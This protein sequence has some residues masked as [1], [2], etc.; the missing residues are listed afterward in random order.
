MPKAKE[1]KK[2]LLDANI[3]GEMV[4]DVNIEQLKEE[5][6]K[7]KDTMLIYGV[8]EIIRKELR[9]TPKDSKVG[10]KKLRSNLLGLYDIFTRSHELSLAEEHKK[11]ADDYYKAY[12]ELGGSKPKDSILNDLIIGFNGIFSEHCFFIFAYHNIHFS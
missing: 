7:C 1:S 12:R 5:Y 11:L 8:K 4:I 2:Y 3:Y 9:A 10:E 6:E